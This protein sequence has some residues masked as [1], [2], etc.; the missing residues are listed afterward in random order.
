MVDTPGPAMGDRGRPP[1]K[2][3]PRKQLS[4]VLPPML[5]NAIKQRSRELNLTVTAY[6]IQLVRQ[7]LNWSGMGDPSTRERLDHIEQRLQSLEN[8]EQD[9]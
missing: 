8:H 1:L 4:M 5:L 9:L 6:I 2:A 3:E 7:D